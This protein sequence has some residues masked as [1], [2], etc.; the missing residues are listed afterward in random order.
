MLHQETGELQLILQISLLDQIKG[1]FAPRSLGCSHRFMQLRVDPMA[2]RLAGKIAIVTGCGSGIGRGCALRFAREG[3]HVVGVDINVA[4]ARSTAEDSAERGYVIEICAPCDL[5]DE[6]AVGTLMAEAARRHGGID[7]LVTAAAFVEMGSVAELTYAQWRRSMLGELD[8]VFL[9]CKAVW[10]YMIERG[11]GSII[12]FASINA[13]MA[14]KMTA[15]LAHMATKGG[16][17]AMTKQLAMEGGPHKIRANS[18]SPGLTLTD[19]TGPALKAVP[20]LEQSLMSKMMLGRFGTP[21]DIAGAAV[22]LA[23]DEAA[24]V[25]GADLAV[26]GGMSAW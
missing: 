8:I 25:T 14:V 12:N 20:G 26:D 6:G 2:G 1:A 7:I 16:V 15:C 5:V 13:R 22:Y 18:I 23:S 19:A 9:S 4:A 3:A 11:G 24:W 10:P 17:F 21:E